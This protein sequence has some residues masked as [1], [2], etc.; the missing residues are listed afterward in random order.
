MISKDQVNRLLKNKLHFYKAMKANGYFMP[1]SKSQF[2]SL[3]FMQEVFQELCYC[4]KLADVHFK[5]CLHP[6]TKDA[7]VVELCA[8]FAQKDKFPNERT[9][10]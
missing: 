4:P 6:P 10:K 8:M 1:E 2:C 5:S 9:A 3:K 7:L